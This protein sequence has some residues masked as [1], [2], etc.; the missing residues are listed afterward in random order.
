MLN[1]EKYFIYLDV[2]GTDTGNS[3]KGFDKTKKHTFTFSER[4]GSVVILG[5]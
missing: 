3:L 2:F 1:K 4:Y 5:I